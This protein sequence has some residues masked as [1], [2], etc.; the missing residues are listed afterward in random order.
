MK[1]NFF[2]LLLFCILGLFVFLAVP[3]TAFADMIYPLASIPTISF[4]KANISFSENARAFITL[5]FMGLTF[6]IISELAATFIFS[7]IKSFIINQK[8]VLSIIGANLISLPLFWMLFILEDNFLFHYLPRTS[9]SF[10]LL[11][12]LLFFGEVLVVIFESIFIYKLNSY[13]FTQGQ[14]FLLSIIMNLASVT[15]GNLLG[16]FSIF[17]IPLVI[18]FLIIYLLYLLLKLLRDVRG[19]NNTEP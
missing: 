11:L 1:N 19:T 2:L 6:T 3:K 8:L 7:K 14:T 9:F 17:I 12:L 15:F 4:N 16:L 18:F 10:G 13:L 5:L